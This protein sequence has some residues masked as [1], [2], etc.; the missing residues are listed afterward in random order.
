MRA[1]QQR[2]TRGVLNGQVQPPD[3][4]LQ[5]RPELQPERSR[6]GACCVDPY[7][8][9]VT[10]LSC[11]LVTLYF[12]Y[13]ATLRFVLAALFICLPLL[14]ALNLNRSAFLRSGY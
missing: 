1:V 4:R 14:F 5:A 7:L 12:W 3:R 13:F 2:S 6:R 9:L 10:L 8:Y 11:P